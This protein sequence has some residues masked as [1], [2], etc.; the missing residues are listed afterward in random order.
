MQFKLAIGNVVQVPVKFTFKEG[1]VNKLFTF[2][3]TA[4][5]KT[6]DEMESQP[7]ISVLDFLYENVTDWT[8]QRLI[9]QDNNEPAAFSREAFEYLLK[10]PDVFPLV[11]AA[12]KRECGAKK[13]TSPGRQTVGQRPAHNP[14][15]RTR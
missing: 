2:T 15:G 4:N 10:L 9:L 11:W 13:K 12:Y 7:E 14:T 3:L 5:R 1:N 8:G 6:P